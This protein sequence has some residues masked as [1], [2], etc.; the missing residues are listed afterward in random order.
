M[1]VSAPEAEPLLFRINHFRP[2]AGFVLLLLLSYYYGPSQDLS[3]FLRYH[4]YNPVK[5]YAALPSTVSQVCI[6]LLI[7]GLLYLRF[8]HLVRYYATL[9]F[10]SEEASDEILQ[11]N[12]ECLLKRAEEVQR[13]LNGSILAGAGE[14][15]TAK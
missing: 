9:L 5:A 3:T 11:R 6:P 10:W 1:P 8:E 14:T 7:V 15:S 4:H 13:A 2:Y 12:K